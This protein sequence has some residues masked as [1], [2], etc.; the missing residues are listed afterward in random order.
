MYLIKRPLR[1]LIHSLKIKEFITIKQKTTIMKKGVYSKP[2][3]KF[4][5]IE[6][7]D[8]CAGS[9]NCTT[10]DI[11]VMGLQKQKNKTYSFKRGDTK[12]MWESK[13]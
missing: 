1:W 6:L 5:A 3:F 12:N 8:L 11:N 4:V 9:N 2:M 13:F 7:N 10:I